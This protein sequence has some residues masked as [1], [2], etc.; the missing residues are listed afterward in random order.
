MEWL[1]EM[2]VAPSYQVLDVLMSAFGGTGNG[3][4]PQLRDFLARHGGGKR[5]VFI[6]YIKL[7]PEENDE[8]QTDDS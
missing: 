1:R 8:V 6:H 4:F 7:D 5:V 2:V 3:I